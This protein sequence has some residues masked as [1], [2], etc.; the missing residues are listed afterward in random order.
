MSALKAAIDQGV[1]SVTIEA[2][3]P[4]F[5]QYKS[6]ILNTRAC[7]TQLD[8]AVAAVGYGSEGG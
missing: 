7:G 5:Q 8:H 2:D 4:I 1:V 6:G 3:K